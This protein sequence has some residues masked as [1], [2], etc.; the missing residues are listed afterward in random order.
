M[1]LG[2]R[3]SQLA[4]V[5]YTLMVPRNARL[6]SVDVIK[7]NIKIDGLAGTVSDTL[8]TAHRVYRDEK[9][10][11][12]LRAHEVMH[13]DVTDKIVKALPKNTGVSPVLRKIGISPALNIFSLFSAARSL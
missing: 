12:A 6:E 11:A 4:A 10:K 7:G 13:F 5:E 9:Y 8:I 2:S 1:R 3:E